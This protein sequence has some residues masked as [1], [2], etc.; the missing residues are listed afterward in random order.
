MLCEFYNNELDTTVLVI[1]KA[2]LCSSVLTSRD[3]EE[4]IK[5]I[6]KDSEPIIA[7]SKVLQASVLHPLNQLHPVKEEYQRVFLK[8]LIS[9]LEACGEEVSD[10]LYKNYIEKLSSSREL[11]ECHYRHFRI[12]GKG[13]I[14]LQES[15]RF[16]TDGTT[17][18]Q[19][20]EGGLA[21][22][23]WCL[24]HSS[25]IVGKRV[26]E[27]GCGLGLT[28][29]AVSTTCRPLSYTLTD[30][31]PSVLSALSHNLQLNQS[32]LAGI[33]VTTRLLDWEDSGAFGLPNS[34][35][36][37]LAA[38]VVY[39]ERL[40]PALVNT[41][42]HFLCDKPARAVLACTERNRDTLTTF[43]QYLAAKGLVADELPCPEPATFRYSTTPPIR[44]FCCSARIQRLEPQYVEH[45]E[46]EDRDG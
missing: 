4:V 16:V 29:L 14:T 33:D 13:Y 9:Q 10:D 34:V 41:L 1:Q 35:D 20:W 43:L 31:H 40:F 24:Q 11:Q 38:D 21:L 30:C 25:E 2:F 3:W 18:L 17:G 22:A 5:F 12:D 27:L 23:E 45:T 8:K 26:V 46:R 19:T 7:Q 42:H 37:V 44:L 15:T 36:L 39:D 28:G 32:L 6:R